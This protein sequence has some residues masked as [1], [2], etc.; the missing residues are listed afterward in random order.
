M[1]KESTYR[2]FHVDGVRHDAAVISKAQKPQGYQPSH[3]IAQGLGGA[4][5]WYVDCIG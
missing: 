1:K 2:D 4:M 3:K 5:D